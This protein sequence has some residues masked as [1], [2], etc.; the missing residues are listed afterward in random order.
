MKN[1]MIFHINVVHYSN[2]MRIFSVSKSQS[3]FGSIFSGGNK[4]KDH[5]SEKAQAKE[6]CSGA[7]LP[8]SRLILQTILV[9]QY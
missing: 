7:A 6:Q 9:K 2:H 3:T 8:A 4:Y 5:Q 1:L